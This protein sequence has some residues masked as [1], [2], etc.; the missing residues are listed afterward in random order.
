[1]IPIGI[2]QAIEERGSA[3]HLVVGI[4]SLKIENDRGA[5][6]ADALGDALQFAGAAGGIHDNMAVALG[7]GAEIPFGID[8]GLLHKAS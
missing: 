4:K 6:L 2:E 1:M 5:V 3:Q 7:E 8:D